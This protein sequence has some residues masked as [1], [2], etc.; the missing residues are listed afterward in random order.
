MLGPVRVIHMPW[1]LTR[2]S[3]TAAPDAPMNYNHWHVGPVK[4]I[5]MPWVLMARASAS[6]A[7][8]APTNPLINA[9]LAL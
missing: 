8:I 1:V 6:A 5:H 4:V 9:M 3:A 7:P 2:A